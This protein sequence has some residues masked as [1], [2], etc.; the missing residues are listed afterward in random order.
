MILVD[1]EELDIENEGSAWRND[2]RVAAL[3]VRV[4]GRARQLGLGTDRHL[5]HA[6]I[7]SSD[8][9]TSSD[10]EFEGLSAVARRIKL[11]AVGERAGVVNLD[12]LTLLGESGAVP[13]FGEFDL[14]SH[15][16]V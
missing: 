14:N 3:S 12:R 13:L 15:D 6:L 11:L 5:G 10:F 4:V 16:Q 1:A 2:A 9:L 8:D 7:P